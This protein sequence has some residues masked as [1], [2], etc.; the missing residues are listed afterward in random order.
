MR[1]TRV[2]L[3]VDL[4]WLA[5]FAVSGLVVWRFGMGWVGLAAM[6]LCALAAICGGMLIAAR[7]E[8]TVQRRLA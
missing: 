8:R 1:R 3:L 4:V 5:A 6:A 7:A 2:A